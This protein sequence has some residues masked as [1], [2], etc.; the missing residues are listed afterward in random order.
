MNFKHDNFVAGLMKLLN[1]TTHL[2]QPNYVSAVVLELRKSK[3]LK[4][5]VR[6]LWKNNQINERISL[7]EMN[8]LNCSKACP[9]DTFLEITKSLGN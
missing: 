4:Y 6:A 7:N 8:L 2:S 1:M 5:F 3:D 9:L